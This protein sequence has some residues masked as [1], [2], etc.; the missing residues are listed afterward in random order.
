MNIANSSQSH[1][2]LKS[3]EHKVGT[4]MIVFAAIFLASLPGN[5]DAD[6]LPN[7]R[8]IILGAT[9]RESSYEVA[10][11]L[12]WWSSLQVYRDLHTT[13][14][15]FYQVSQETHI[16]SKNVLFRIWQIQPCQRAAWSSSQLHRRL[17]CCFRLL[18][19]RSRLRRVHQGHLCQ[20]RE[21]CNRLWMCSVYCKTI[22]LCILHHYTW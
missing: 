7:P 18:L 5:I 17:W 19:R 3:R 20:G 8:L 21:V 4:S 1:S 11:K 12:K 22:Y 9:G 6:N 14:Y 2:S 10:I 16:I 15:C 13:R